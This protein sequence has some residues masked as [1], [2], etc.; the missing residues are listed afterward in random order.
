MS[1]ILR[2]FRSVG[3]QLVCNNLINEV[4]QHLKGLT[5]NNSI[6]FI[7]HNLGVNDHENETCKK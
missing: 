1:R 7:Q 2:E 3:I 6:I 5:M 4:Y